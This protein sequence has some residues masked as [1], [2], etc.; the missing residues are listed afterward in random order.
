MNAMI[1]PRTDDERPQTVGILGLGNVLMGDDALGPTVIAQLRADY[2]LA[3]A[4]AV[5]DLGTPGLDLYSHLVAYEAVILVDT[6][7]DRAEPGTVRAYDRSDIMRH[8]P[9][10]RVSP[11]DPGLRE[12][13]LNFE[14]SG[15]GPRTV[16]L[17][18]VIPD[19]VDYGVSLSAA[20]R[21]AVPH[22]I[23]AVQ[24]E[25]EALGHARL[26]PRAEP[27]PSEAWWESPASA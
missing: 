11:H 8:P 17:V 25:L 5:E 4:M 18:G 19:D 12:T 26:R 7:R 15:R 3:D 22:C 1:T 9:G 10:P 27:H 13:L 20:V 16:V 23:E 2:E 6:V 14:L 24:E 21:S